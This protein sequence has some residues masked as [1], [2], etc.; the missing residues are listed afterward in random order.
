MI[1]F[2]CICNDTYV[3]AVFNIH[4]FCEGGLMDY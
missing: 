3:K 1:T 4:I 2:I